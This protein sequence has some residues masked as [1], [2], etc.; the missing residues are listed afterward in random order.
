MRHSVFD[1]ELPA[2]V[3][4]QQGGNCAQVDEPAIK[5]PADPKASRTQSP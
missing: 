3:V 4:K 2:V 5:E 1:V